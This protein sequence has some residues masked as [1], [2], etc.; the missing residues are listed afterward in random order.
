M[1]RAL[2]FLFVAFEV[3]SASFDCA[4]ATK[5]VEKHIC[6]DKQLSTLDDKLASLYEE[7]SSSDLYPDAPTQQSIASQQRN[8]LKTRDRCT[9]KSCLLKLYE[10]RIVDFSCV[11]KKLGGAFSALECSSAKVAV[12]DRRLNNLIERQAQAYSQEISLYDPQ[13]LHQLVIDEAKSWRIHV[14]DKCQLETNG[15]AG[16]VQWDFVYALECELE[17]INARIVSVQTALDAIH[18]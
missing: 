18:K 1:I 16:M 9:T 11:E 10:H 6:S 15:T 4:K 2:F 14:R 3:H 12:A 5:S 7:A 17:T 8:W 13:R